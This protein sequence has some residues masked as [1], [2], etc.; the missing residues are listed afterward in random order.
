MLSAT[1]SDLAILNSGT[2]RSDRIHRKGAFT[3]RD[4]VT[5]LPMMDSLIVLSATGDQILQALENGVSQYP[6]LE[7]RFPQVSGVSFAFDPKKPPGQRIDP[8]FVRIGDEPLD[9]DQKY[10]LVTKNYLAQGKDG[11]DVFKECEVLLREDESPELCTAVQNHF[12]A[13]RILTG[14]AHPRTHH[15]QSLVCLS[16]RHSLVRTCED[17]TTKPPLKRGLSLDAS[18]RRGLFRQR[19]TSLEDVEHET[20]K[21]E[22]KVENRIVILTEERHIHFRFTFSATIRNFR[23]FRVSYRPHSYGRSMASRLLQIK[24]AVTLAPIVARAQPAAA[25]HGR[26]LIGKREVVGFGMNGE[27]SY[28]DNP[29]FP[30]PAIRYKEPTPDI[31]KLREKEKGDWKNLSLEEKKASMAALAVFQGSLGC[32][33]ITFCSP[34]ILIGF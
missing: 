4:L 16:R 14:V 7:G 2:L 9:K 28:I 29:D 15:R 34:I 30:M 12:Q 3:M 23:S 33:H 26:A 19:Q 17:V 1:H 18:A 6:K 10:R 24:R 13:V 20:C 32:T 31:E 25:Y 5:V 8:Q 27:Y 11:Y 22:P 21:M